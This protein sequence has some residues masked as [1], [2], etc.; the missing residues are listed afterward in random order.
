[1]ATVIS[2]TGYLVYSDKF[3][4]KCCG[5]V[6]SWAFSTGKG[7]D[8]DLQIWRPNDKKNKVYELVGVNSYKIPS[9]S[10]YKIQGCFPRLFS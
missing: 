1:M 5:T 10:K 3:V 6:K 4:I 2:A 7:T 9:K 8:V